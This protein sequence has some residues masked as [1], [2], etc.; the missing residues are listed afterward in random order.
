MKVPKKYSNLVDWLKSIIPTDKINSYI[1]IDYEE[2]D[3]LRFILFTKENKYSI[4]AKAPSV[5][6]YICQLCDNVIEVSFVDTKIL[7]KVQ[8]GQCGKKEAVLTRTTGGYL[9]CIATQRKPRAG[10]DWNRGNDLADGDYCYET[11]DAIV[12]DI[13]KYEIVKITSK[14]D[15]WLDKQAKEGDK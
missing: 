3:N 9:G 8:C 6:E 13:V 7:N 11:W 12:R 1:M 5:G 15:Q 4:S 10:E 14:I 2:D